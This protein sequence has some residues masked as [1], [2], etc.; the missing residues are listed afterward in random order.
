VEIIN[1]DPDGAH[2]MKKITNKLFPNKKQDRATV[3]AKLKSLVHKLD[4]TVKQYEGKANAYRIRAKKYLKAGRKE[5]A[6]ASLVKYK[7]YNE[8]SIRY[9]NMKLKAEQHLEALG[10]S[11]V[12]TEITGT[13]A[14]SSGELAKAAQ[15]ANPELA[16]KIMDE[17][18]QSIDAINETGEVLGADPESDLGIDIEDE[19]NEITS[20]LMLEQSGQLVEPTDADL[21]LEGLDAEPGAATPDSKEKVKEEIEKIKKSLKL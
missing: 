18:D 15:R 13:L 11:E 3:V 2:G 4:D 7:Y 16:M 10:E 21:E 6:R 14:E 8:K 1:Y 20:E 12:M 17:A 5:Q 9:S 19:F